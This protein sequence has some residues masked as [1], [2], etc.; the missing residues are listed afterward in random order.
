MALVREATRI[1]LPK[2]YGY[3]KQGTERAKKLGAPFML[4]EGIDGN[5]LFNRK[6]SFEDLP[7]EHRT[8]LVQ[9]WAVIQ[10]ELVTTSFDKIVALVP[11]P[12]LESTIVGG[13]ASEDAGK[14]GLFTDSVDFLA[15]LAR[16]KYE[17]AYERSVEEQS[18]Y[19]FTKIGDSD[20]DWDKLR[21]LSPADPNI[22]LTDS[23]I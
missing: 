18:G 17:S 5:T 21:D 13:I 11:D 1:P 19:S 2:L 20:E 9:Q 22:C 6:L 4:L 15:A 8:H 12:V 14:I 10:A 3:A 7:E 23:R 16:E